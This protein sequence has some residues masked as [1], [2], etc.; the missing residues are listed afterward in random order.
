VRWSISIAL[1]CTGLGAHGGPVDFGLGE[2]NA[3]LAARNLKMRIKYDVSLEPPGTFRIEP[4]AAGGAHITGGDLR[5]LMY[6]LL[7][8]ADQVRTAGHMKPA[9]EVPSIGLRSVRRFARDDLADWRPYFETLARDRFNHLTLIYTEPPSD[10]KKLRAISQDAADYAVDFTLALWF[11]PDENIGKIIAACPLIRTVQI[12]SASHNVERY[13]AYVFQPIRSAGR[14][15]ALDPDPELVDATQQES[16]ALPG[17]PSAD[18]LPSWPPNF[19]IEAPAD[20]ES[21]AEFYW[22]WGRLGYDPKAKPVHGESADDLSAAAQMIAGI[23]EAKAPANDWVASMDEVVKNRENNIAS[24]KYTPLNLARAIQTA[25]ALEESAV[26]DL[27]L[28]A[29]MGR[30]EATKLRDAYRAVMPDGEASPELPAPLFKHAIVHV[31]PPDKAIELTLQIAPI[32]DVRVVRLHYRALNSSTTM[33]IEKPAALSVSFTIPPTT[34]DLL[35][36][37]EIIDKGSGGWFEPDPAM[38]APYHV[39]RIQAPTPP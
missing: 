8:A 7:E 33:V 26:P 20:F 23:A 5:G 28:L 4:Y 32:K 12:R 10:L 17:N 36:Y 27:R 39:I 2:F 13:R 21:H 31:S 19:D 9:H 30:G 25:A 35:Y 1:L 34:A 18:A 14:R 37:F 11:E 6:G 29:T 15:I 16:V 22:L 38:A 3:A 24:A